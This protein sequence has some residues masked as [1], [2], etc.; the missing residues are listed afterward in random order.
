M[1][2][3][4]ILFVDWVTFY[5]CQHC[6]SDFI[7]LSILQCLSWLSSYSSCKNHHKSNHIIWYEI[8]RSDANQMPGLCF[9]VTFDIISNHIIS[10]VLMYFR[11][12]A[13]VG[14]CVIFLSVN[15]L[16]LSGIARASSWHNKYPERFSWP[17]SQ[18]SLSSS[19]T[20]ISSPSSMPI[21][22]IIV[23]H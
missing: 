3:G 14:V 4:W 2:L 8:G 11:C 5:H 12:L 16:A 23:N 1:R 13:S 17:S 9:S 10:Y 18:S 21:A 20:S 19:P 22:K 6:L 15:L 7:S